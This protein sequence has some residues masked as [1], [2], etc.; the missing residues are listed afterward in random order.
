MGDSECLSF[1]LPELYWEPV[2]TKVGSDA[3]RKTQKLWHQTSLGPHPD[4][5]PPGGALVVVWIRSEPLQ[6]PGCR[7]GIAYSAL[8]LSRVWEQQSQADR[9]LQSRSLEGSSHEVI[10]INETLV[11]SRESDAVE[12]VTGSEPLTIL[13][14]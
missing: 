4:S 13:L 3:K 8:S 7:E 10:M 9:M 5:A 2:H 11:R 12:E 1:G 14:L 6:C